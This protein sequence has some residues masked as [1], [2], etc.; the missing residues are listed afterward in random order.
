MSFKKDVQIVFQDPG[1]S[2]NPF[3]DI[4]QILKLPLRVHHI[5]PRTAGR[6]SGR[7]SGQGRIAAQFCIQN[8]HVDRR[9]RKTAGLHRPRPLQQPKF[10]ILDEPTSSLDVSI[11]AKIINMLLKLHQEEKLTYLSL[12][13]T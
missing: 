3:Q 12:P 9:R 2:L 11:Q 6:S 8:P 5:V 13:M 7:G 4:R 1:S 10:I